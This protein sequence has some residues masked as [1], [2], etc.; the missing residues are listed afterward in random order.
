MMPN[1]KTGTVTKEVGKAVRAAKAGAV[2]FKVE[3]NGIIHAGIGKKSFTDEALLG[4]IRAF[5]LAVVEVKPE[6]LKGKYLE[7][8]HIS[9]TMGPGVPVELPTVDPGNG[10]FM[11]DLSIKDL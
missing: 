4:N 6:G 1:P 3:K 2:K 5:M 7:G 10:R 11:L 9:C 8:A